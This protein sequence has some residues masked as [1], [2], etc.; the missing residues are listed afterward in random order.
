MYSDARFRQLMDAAPV[1][2]WCAD[3]ERRCIYFNKVWLDFTG[4]SMEQEFGCGWVSGVHPEDNPGRAASYDENFALHRPFRIEYRLRRHD[5]AWRWM[6]ATG[7]PRTDPLG[8]F[9]G[10]IGTCV[11][12]TD[13]KEA[14]AQRQRDLDERAALLQELHHRVK[15][16]AQVFASLLAVQ[17]SRACEKPVQAALRSAA[18]RALVMALAQQVVHEA[19]A[20][21][22][23]EVGGLLRRLADS[24]QRGGAVVE[25][26]AEERVFAPL[27]AAVPLAL[28]VHELLTNAVRHAFP[29]DEPGRVA[30]SLDRNR[31]GHLCLRVSDDG[32]GMAE[33][34]GPQARRST[35]LTIV[36][37][38]AR[39]LGAGLSFDKRG[40][41]QVC[42]ALPWGGQAS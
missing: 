6:L 23:F 22:N 4:R 21:P 1:L 12:V 17:A 10:F 35:G 7:V 5:G 38:L 25:V 19:G 16:N 14:A 37:S 34:A 13:M 18:A 33:P 41:T 30:V 8:A 28:I 32:V 29:Q 15:N 24:L 20:S 40:G 42:L 36:R 3:T 26:R 39:Q 9:L 27:A 11:D 31:E 2:I